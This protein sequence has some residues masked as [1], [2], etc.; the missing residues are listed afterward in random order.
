MALYHFHADLIRRS[1]GQSV[2]TAAAYRAGEKLRCDYYGN[3]ADYTR[4]KGVVLTDILFPPHAPK[5]YADRETLWNAVEQAEKNTK[6]Q[7]AYSYDIALQNELSIEENIAL[8]WQFLQEQFVSKGMIV[9]LPSIRRTW[10][11]AAFRIRIFTF[12]APSGPST[13]PA[14]GEQSSAGNM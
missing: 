13:K 12:S 3:E 5:E 2:V 6:A 7:L 14:N 9:I 11:A 4:K 8:A 10:R 1:K